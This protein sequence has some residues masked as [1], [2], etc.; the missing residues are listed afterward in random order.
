MTLLHRI[1]H[2][3]LGAGILLT[4]CVSAILLRLFLL[5]VRQP[6]LIESF[7]HTL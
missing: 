4:L 6:Q 1:E 2:M 3:L 5:Y 7:T